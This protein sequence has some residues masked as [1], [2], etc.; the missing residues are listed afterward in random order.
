MLVLVWWVVFVFFFRL[1]VFYP[2][3]FFCFFIFLGVVV[4]F[5]FVVCGFSLA[6]GGARLRVCGLRRGV[7]WHPF[8]P[9]SNFLLPKCFPIHFALGSRARYS[10]LPPLEPI[11]H[12][13]AACSLLPSFTHQ[14]N[15][16]C[17]FSHP[18]TSLV[19]SLFPGKV[20]SDH[21][22]ALFLLPVLEKFFLPSF[23]SSR[24]FP[25]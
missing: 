25:F 13:T 14:K 21:S 19:S 2:S 24:P 10:T 20:P 12:S 7:W 11:L 15:K 16:D 9:I 22:A 8:P 17:F 1:R 18:P 23:S 5:C 4:V 3:F 6:M